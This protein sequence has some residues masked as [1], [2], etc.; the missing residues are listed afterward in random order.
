M[1]KH[2][3]SVLF[4]QR[5]QKKTK[6]KSNFIKNI[7]EHISNNPACNIQNNAGMGHPYEKEYEERINKNNRRF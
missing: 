6:K 3:F 5:P 2:H 7:L 4:K 1:K